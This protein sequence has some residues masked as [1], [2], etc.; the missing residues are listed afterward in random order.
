MK[1]ILLVIL[2]ATATSSTTTSLLASLSRKIEGRIIGGSTARAGEFPFS[3][4]I[5]IH[6][7]NGQYFCGGAL[8]DREWVL[9]AAQCVDGALQ[10]TIVLGSNNL[11]ENEPNRVTVAAEEH[12]LNPNYDAFTLQHDIALIKLRMPVELTN[13]I[14]PIRLPTADLTTHSVAV[15]TGWGQTSDEDAGT[16]SNLNRVTITVLSNEECRL[17]YGTQI[18][19]EMVCAEGNYNEGTCHGDSG[20]GLIQ[21]FVGEPAAIV[22][23]SSFFSSRGCESTDPSGFTRVFP[24]VEWIKNT[25]GIV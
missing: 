23:I 16:V 2:Y 1:L 7:S 9:T 22:G 5:N 20:S 11:N 12:F 18:I 24:Y 8:I 15:A 25:T 19:D 21:Y 13:Y 4:A 3:A 10:F 6:A 17:T 14:Q